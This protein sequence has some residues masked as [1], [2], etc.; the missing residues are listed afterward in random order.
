LVAHHLDGNFEH[1][2]F[3]RLVGNVGDLVGQH[4]D[5]GRVVST[6]VQGL[7]RQSFFAHVFHNADH[8]AHLI[9]KPANLVLDRLDV[10]MMALDH[11]VVEGDLLF[12]SHKDIAELILAWRTIWLVWLMLWRTHGGNS[13][14][15]VRCQRMRL[16]LRRLLLLWLFL[17]SWLWL[18]RWWRRRVSGRGHGCRCNA[19]WRLCDIYYRPLLVHGS[20]APIQRG[21]NVLLVRRQE[22]DGAIDAA[23]V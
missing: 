17:F 11:A 14:M 5:I 4:L 20:L 16:R 19:N 21:A 15:A 13:G 18:G 23:T 7:W 3:I 1:V 8:L 2:D 12:E 6:G 10:G 9:L 22:S